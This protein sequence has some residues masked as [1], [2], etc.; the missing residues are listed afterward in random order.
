MVEFYKTETAIKELDIRIIEDR[1][2]YSLPK[3]YR[4]HLLVNNGGKCKPDV[5]TFME[6]NKLSKSKI[7]WFLA[8]YDGK[9]DNLLKYID[10]YKFEQKRIPEY[11]IPIAHDPGG[12]LIC[13]SCSCS[14]YGYIYFWDHEKETPNNW[15][16]CSTNIYLIANSFDNFIANLTHE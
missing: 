14:D 11:F 10:I 8:I 6:G 13:I 4:S 2:G 15:E 5:F 12:N 7:D 9:Y 1:V 3:E 16:D